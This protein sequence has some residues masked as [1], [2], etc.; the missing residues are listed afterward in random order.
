MDIQDSKLIMQPLPG[1]SASHPSAEEASSEEDLPKNWGL[2]QDI[3][4]THHWQDLTTSKA[5]WTFKNTVS[6]LHCLPQSSNACNPLS[7]DLSFLHDRLSH[8][9]GPCIT[10]SSFPDPK[11]VHRYFHAHWDRIVRNEW[12]FLCLVCRKDPPIM[13]THHSTK[14]EF[15][16][17]YGSM[18]KGYQLRRRAILTLNMANPEPKNFGE[19]WGL[20]KF[21]DA[22]EV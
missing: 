11:S 6:R 1:P 4:L 3:Y 21:Q 8:L 13:F 22:A 12:R 10:E 9:L 16:A 5:L 15:K 20:K 7:Y 19:F 18:E 17:R 14:K 2:Q